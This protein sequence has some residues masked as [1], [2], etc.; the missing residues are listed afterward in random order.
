MMRATPPSLPPCLLTVA[1]TDPCGASGVS[2]D[3]QVFRD[4]GAHG[5]SAIS[6]LVWQNT[7]GVRGYEAVSAEV[8]RAQLDAIFEDLPVAGVKLGM[9][10]SG[11]AIEVVCEAL[12]A[13]PTLPVVC[14]P[15]MASGDGAKPL[16]RRSA[17]D[18]LREHLLPHVDV[19]TPNIPEASV[20]LGR[21]LRTAADLEGAARQLSA[22]VRVGVLLKVGHWPGVDPALMQD[23]WAE[24]GQAPVWLEPLARVGED[25]RGTGCQLASAILAER[26]GGGGWLGAAQSARRYLGRLLHRRAMRPGQGRAMIIRV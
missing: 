7:Q 16:M 2:V 11:E 10:P 26:V 22:L 18:H 6:A 21:P 1:G 25:V 15:V 5:L 9:L 19:L 8:L 17:L 3:L 23:L 13:R 20:L 14:D 4:Y 12:R 24:R